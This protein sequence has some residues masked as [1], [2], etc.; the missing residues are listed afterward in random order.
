MP[1]TATFRERLDGPPLLADGAMGTALHARGFGFDRCFEELNVTQPAVVADIHRGYVEAGA[2]LLFTNSFGANHYRLH[3]FGLA[4][5]V[6]E[7]NAAAVSIA[8]RVVAAAFADVHIAGDV[9]PLGV[10]LAPYGRV[11]EED[12]K[13]AFRDQIEALAGAGAELIAIETMLDLRELAVAIRVAR[14]LTTLPVVAMMSFTRDDRTLLGEDPAAVAR[15]LVDMGADVIGV[16]CSSGP[17]QAV[18]I[19]SAM[20]RAAP[21]ARLA[22]KPNAGWPEQVGGRIIYPATP[23]YFAECAATFADVG[24]AII[25]GCCGTTPQHIAAMGVALDALPRTP[26]SQPPRA[27]VI[28][29]AP[30]EPQSSVEPPTQLADKLARGTFVIGVEMHP[31]RGFSTHKLLAGAHLLAESGADVI[32]VADSPMARMRM[33]AWA[34]CHLVGSAA[35]IE[36]VLHFPLRGRNLLRLQGDLLAA[37]ALG[38]RNIFVVMGDPTAIG[39]YPTATDRYDLVPSGLIRLIKKGFNLGVDH[40]G[41]SIGQPTSFLVG[42]AVNLVATNPDKEVNS[43]HK[44]IVAGADFALTQPVYETAPARTF[45]R[46]YEDRYGRLA[47]PLLV[48][49]L[50]LYNARHATFL[51][52]EV[53]GISIPERLRARMT[54]AGDAGSAEGMRI[55]L[56]LLVELRE[57]VQGVYLMPPFSRYDLAADIIQ[58]VRQRSLL[59]G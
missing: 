13:A 20:R 17:A 24:A 15:Q 8:Q 32:N 49:V 10:R 56:D 41:V 6:A 34:V 37:H 58:Q 33:S 16:N 26:R 54:A 27:S 55:A 22:V 25:G 18:R 35:G 19:L 3:Q 12:A 48:G 46:R 23:A 59:A 43:L 50:P 21:A 44:K 39:D 1:T 2:R 5:R 42:C 53:P 31:P 45:L 47:L 14:A 29:P 28:A 4:D 7:L 38:I 30:L 36:T 57:V 11:R 40:A 52:N 51:H 9:G